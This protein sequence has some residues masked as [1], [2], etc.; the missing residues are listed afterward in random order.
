MVQ[1]CPPLYQFFLWEFG[2]LVR[3][4]KK[5]AKIDNYAETARMKEIKR[6][7]KMMEKIINRI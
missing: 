6:V 3:L 4:A 2:L 7:Q 1:G 5:Y